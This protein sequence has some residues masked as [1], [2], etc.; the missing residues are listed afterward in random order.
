MVP[1]RLSGGSSL[2]RQA[3]YQKPN[4]GAL[5]EGL[6]SVMRSLFMES[7][8]MEGG[9]GSS[10]TIAAVLS[11]VKV[12]AL[13]RKRSGDYSQNPTEIAVFMRT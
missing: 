5:L 2:L 8:G 9:I 7:N 13:T 3:G 4:S 11:E 6:I 10:G 1:F 12:A